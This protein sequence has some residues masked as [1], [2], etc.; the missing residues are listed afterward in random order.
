MHSSYLLLLL[1]TCSNGCWPCT[2]PA[3]A[4]VLYQSRKTEA[5]RTKVAVRFLRPCTERR[6][7]PPVLSSGQ[8]ERKSKGVRERTPCFFLFFCLFGGQIRVYDGADDVSLWWPSDA[9]T[10][11]LRL[12]PFLSTHFSPQFSKNFQLDKLDLTRPASSCH[13]STPGSR[14][15][16]PLPIGGEIRPAVRWTPPT[17]G[18]LVPRDR[19]TISSAA[20]SV[21]PP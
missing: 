3:G 17:V 20:A 2:A 13:S 21:S 7:P 18:C 6:R 4:R 14:S 11:R 10:P 12:C 15:P 5:G 8:V 19:R 9:A 1:V 16:F